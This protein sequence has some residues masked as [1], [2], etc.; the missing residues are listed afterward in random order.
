MKG[1]NVKKLAAIATGAALLA[2]AI[3]PIV[4]ATNATKDDI[5]NSSGSPNVNIVIGSEAALSG[6]VRNVVVLDEDGED[7]A[8]DIMFFQSLV[9][10]GTDN[11]AFAPSDADLQ[12][13]V[14]VVV[15][16]AA[17]YKAAGTPSV[18][19]VETN[20]HMQLEGSKSLFFQLISRGT[21]TYTATTDLQLRFVIEQ[22]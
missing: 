5:Y 13:S 4:S 22:D 8:F 14:G 12:E 2:T 15:V 16:A 17:D 19:T 20:L 11:V 21:P 9:T 18:A 6:I 10:G 7:A 3:A 1:F